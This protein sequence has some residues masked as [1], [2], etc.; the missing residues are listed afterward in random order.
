MG[1]ELEMEAA[2]VMAWSWSLQKMKSEERAL[3][4]GHCHV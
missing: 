2:D 1:M 4:T 3:Q